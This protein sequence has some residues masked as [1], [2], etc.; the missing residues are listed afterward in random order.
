MSAGVFHGNQPSM[1][2]GEVSP[3]IHGRTDLA[4]YAIAMRT[5]RNTFVL[6][7]GGAANRA[8]T[9][10][11]GNVLDHNTASRSIPFQFNS[12]QTYALIFGHLSVLVFYHGAQVIGPAKDITAISKASPAVAT[13]AAHGYVS[14]SLVRIAGALGMTQL[15]DGVYEVGAVTADT[16]EIVGVNSSA[17][18]T[19]AGGATSTWNGVRTPYIEDDLFKLTYMQS[20]D[21]LTIM[22]QGYDQHD[23]SR[24]DNDKWTLTPHV[25]GPKIARP[26][27]LAAVATTAGG[28]N[29][30]AMRYVV[31]AV[32]NAES[33]FEESI[34]SAVA[35]A[36]NNL[37]TAGSQNR[38]TWLAVPGASHYYVYKES[39][40]SGYYGFIGRADGLAFTDDN[41]GPN[42]GSSPVFTTR[43][44]FAGALDKPSCGTHF[45]QRRLFAGLLSGP[46][47]VLGSQT[48]NFKNM[49]ISSPSKADD[50]ITFSVDSDQY[51]SIKHMVPTTNLI[52]F[53]TGGVFRVV[54]GSDNAPLTP[55]SASPLPQ[56]DIGSGD[57][58]PI[59]ISNTILGVD[60]TGRLVFDLNYALETDTY[61][62]GDRS[63]LSEHLLEDRHIVDWAYARRPYGLIWAV[64]SD[65]AMLSLTYLREHQVVAWC[66]HD[67]DGFYESVCVVREGR[68]DVPYFVVRRTI[69]GQT[70]RYVE[71]MESRQVKTFDDCFFV[72]CGLRYSGPPVSHFSGLD[73]L[74]GKTVSILADGN[75]VP[76]QVVTNGMITLNRNVSSIVA[77]LPYKTQIETLQMNVDLRDGT[78]Q[79]R[80]MKVE[81]VTLSLFRSRGFTVGPDDSTQIEAKAR[82]TENYGEP[83]ALF[84]GKRKVKVLPQWNEHGRVLIEQ[85]QPLPLLVRSIIPRYTAGN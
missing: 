84:T 66:R 64:L 52:L 80:T 19:Y 11:A 7:Q 3:L 12:S 30:K 76:S 74:E 16:F 23:L 75:V 43:N 5:M 1:A 4:A 46:S 2:A 68:E 42:V 13:S 6:A 65:G 53:T 40:A 48:G 14:G 31:T 8:G 78:S 55:T 34:A 29:L 57:I 50:A 59:K 18:S 15:V 63:I 73:H 54:A 20:A 82:T 22:G 28:S 9:S 60:D 72:D 24:L 61:Q 17:Y 70:R 69:N 32:A 39:Q 51:N 38:L 35:T 77:G 62:D 26:T 21:V 71:R 10:Y 41:L 49:N 27:G 67:T 83:I 85:S 44:P 47:K 45:Q 58:A 56:V 25:F 81:H 36:T 79:D 33:N 37:E